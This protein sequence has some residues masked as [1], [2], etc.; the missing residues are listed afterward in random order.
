V[1]PTYAIILVLGLAGYWG[2]PWWLVPAGAAALTLGAWW[3]KLVQPGRQ[4]RPA[5][6][7]K[8]TT[9]FVTGV[10]LDIALAT[11]AFGAGRIVRSVLAVQGG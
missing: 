11:L 6:S 1:S 3:T 10:V 7:S 2:A 5:W 9:Y 8:T 4:P